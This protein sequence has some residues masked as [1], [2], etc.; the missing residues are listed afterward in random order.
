MACSRARAAAITGAGQYGAARRRRSGL[1]GFLCHLQDLLAGHG[2]DHVR[3]LVLDVRF[4]VSD[5][6]VV[7]FPAH[8]LAAWAVDL[9]GHLRSFLRVAGSLGRRDLDAE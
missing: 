5:E 6:L 2:P 8:R 9:L 4:D 1:R 7:A 3:M